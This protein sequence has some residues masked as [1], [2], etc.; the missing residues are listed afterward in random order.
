MASNTL[1]QDS[2]INTIR[3]AGEVRVQLAQVVS[4][5]SNKTCNITNQILTIQIFEDMFSPFITGS[6]IFRES[7]DLINALPFIGS[8]YIDLLL[9]TP[10]LDVTLKEKAMITGRFYIYKM[11][12][13]EYV[14]EKNIVYQLHF[15]SEEAITDLNIR[16]SKG[17]NGKISD[18]IVDLVKGKNNLGSNKPLVLEQT[19][20]STKY[21]SNYWPIT[22]NI[23]FLLQQSS[24]LNSSATYSFFENR[25]G[26]NYVSLDYLNAEDVYQYFT[27][28]SST[29]MVDSMGGSSRNIAR[30][31]SKI[32]ELT[33]PTGFDYIDRIRTGTYASKLIIHDMTTKRYKT[34]TY[35]YLQKFNEGSETRLNKFPITT[36]NII[37][38]VYSTIFVNEVA[39]SVFSNYGDV[40]N[41]RVVQDRTSRI[42]QAESFK[43]QIKVNGR[44]DYTVGQ[45][46]YLNINTIHPISE[47]DTPTETM[48]KMYSGNYLISAIRHVIDRQRHECFMELIKDS[49]IF[50]TGTGNLA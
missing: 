37:A 42:K 31:Y 39:N 48:D 7:L 44:T 10:G 30:D 20:N 36:P 38:R 3:Q 23:N 9:F 15:I 19:K 5:A 2:T 16:L 12:E 40:S 21:I 26:F 34:V 33:V 4:T 45:K 49:L 29:D 35:D 11:T 8:E 24:S 28:G 17:F 14:L 41:V 1:N 6:I 18:M 46:V 32:L 43:L 50:N 13:R 22:K 25:N 27:L 47:K